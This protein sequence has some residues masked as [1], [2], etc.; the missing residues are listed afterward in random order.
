MKEEALEQKPAVLLTV[1]DSEGNVVRRLS[2]PA[3]EGMHRVTWDLR[4]PSTAV[5]PGGFFGPGNDSGYLAAPGTYTVT[6]ALRYGR[7]SA[8]DRFGDLRGG[9]VA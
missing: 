4:Y 6:M 5:T 3:K 9:A 7:R 1:A 8:R 2:G